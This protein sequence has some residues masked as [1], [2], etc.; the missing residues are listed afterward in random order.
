MDRVKKNAMS[1]RALVFSVLK[2]QA[3][4]TAPRIRNRI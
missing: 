4:G 3:T 2:N 1:G